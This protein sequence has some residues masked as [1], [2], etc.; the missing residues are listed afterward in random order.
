MV[1]RGKEDACRSIFL[2]NKLKILCDKISLRC[3]FQFCQ[4]PQKNGAKLAYAYLSTQCLMRI[5]WNLDT[6]VFFQPYVIC[7]ISYLLYYV[8]LCFREIRIKSRKPTCLR[9]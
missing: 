9:I 7:Y 4:I 2:N 1:I 5:L 3:G 8:N 6:D